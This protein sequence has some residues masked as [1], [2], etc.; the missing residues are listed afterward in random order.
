METT[1]LE[2]YITEHPF[3]YGL[4]PQHLKL[5]TGCAKSAVFDAGTYAF[6]QGENADWFFLVRDGNV[7]IEVPSARGGLV[8][9]STV[10]PGEIFGWSWL[11]PPHIYEFDARALEK[12]RV[13][14]LEG[15]CLRRKCE[16]D[17]NMGFEL[18]KRFSKVMT[19]RLRS[20]R[21]QLMDIYANPQDQ[22][23]PDER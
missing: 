16:A 8:R 14:A 7:A 6:K 11:M 18:M 9:V 12:T 5:I 1:D 10:G 17:Q 19:E 23:T 2:P 3:F 20:A 13:I 22:S 4:D 21:I 15:K